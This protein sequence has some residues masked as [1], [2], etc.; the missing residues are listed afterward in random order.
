M[1][2]YLKN[3][4]ALV[5]RTADN[6]WGNWSSEITLATNDDYYKIYGVFMHEK[7]MK[8]NGKTVYFMMSQFDLLYDAYVM[9]VVFR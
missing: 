4:Y 7:L 9:E 1:I 5:Y 2:G 3:G 6:P 8:D